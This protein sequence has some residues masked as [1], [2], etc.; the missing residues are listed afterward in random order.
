MAARIQ[1]AQHALSAVTPLASAAHV[2]PETQLGPAPPPSHQPLL[3]YSAHVQDGSLD[4]TQ[5]GVSVHVSAQIHAYDYEAVAV[6]VC[7]KPKRFES[8]ALNYRSARIRMSWPLRVVKKSTLFEAP[9]H[10]GNRVIR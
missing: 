7:K 2:H 10:A 8:E 9:F 4:G 3:L 6:A 1:Q 5:A